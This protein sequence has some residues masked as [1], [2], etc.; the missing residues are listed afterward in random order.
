M[1]IENTDKYVVVRDVA[2]AYNIQFLG[3]NITPKR[4]EEM[5]KLLAPLHHLQ[6][7]N[8]LPQIAEEKKSKEKE[9]RNIE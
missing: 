8:A 3:K 1:Q 6:P 2:N 7:G 4:L 5:H 9:R